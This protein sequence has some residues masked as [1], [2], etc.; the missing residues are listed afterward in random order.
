MIPEPNALLEFV[1]GLLV[2]FLATAAPA[3]LARRAAE[4]TIDAYKATGPEQLVTV[5]RLVTFAFAA[6][7][8]IRLSMPPELDLPMKLKLRGNAGT[9]DR[10]SH[11][12]SAV[13]DR[14][15]QAAPPVQRDE[16]EV[17]AALAEAQQ[18]VRA[19][20]EAQHAACQAPESQ[21]AVHHSQEA[22]LAVRQARKPQSQAPDQPAARP[23]QP[24]GPAP[25]APH[26]DDVAWAT[27]MTQVATEF[28]AELPA[29]P[30]AQQQAQLA[31]IAALA[32]VSGALAKGEA[33][34]RKARL[35]HST[36]L[37]RLPFAPTPRA[38][39]HAA[40]PQAAALNR[41]AGTPTAGPG[42]LEVI[43][44]Q[45]PGDV[46]RLA[47]HEQPRHGVGPQRPR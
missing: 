8:N 38:D 22:Q 41:V 29:M 11:R 47:D 5:S 43:P 36:T 46:H 19:A 30:H 42:P 33:P 40:Q 23:T 34:P 39:R 7:D 27:A 14:Q 9:L 32:H 17:L 35:L 44:T 4:E 16:A 6:L 3:E 31:R 37:E 1:V 15:R 2:P 13:L 28:T 45:P 12:A 25:S 24:Y 26:H 10:A 20:Q 18:A 21:H